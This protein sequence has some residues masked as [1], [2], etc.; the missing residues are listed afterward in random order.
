MTLETKRSTPDKLADAWQ[1]GGIA[2]VLIVGWRW[3]TDPLRRWLHDTYISRH[4]TLIVARARLAGRPVVHTIGD[5]HSIPLGGVYPFRVTWLGG[6]TA[7]NLDKSGSTTGSFL[8][9]A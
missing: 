4:N 7:H 2:R 9:G 5:S 1:Q 8:P 3:I 6:A